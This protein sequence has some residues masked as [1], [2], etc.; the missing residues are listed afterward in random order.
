MREISSSGTESD[1]LTTASY[2]IG[3]P[4]T[5]LCDIQCGEEVTLTADTR[6]AILELPEHYETDASGDT[7]LHPS[8]TYCATADGKNW[9][10]IKRHQFRADL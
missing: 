9:I 2:L 8:G 6:V 4:A 1:I 5:L 3:F 10:D 7:A